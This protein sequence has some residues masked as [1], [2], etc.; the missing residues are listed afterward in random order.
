MKAVKNYAGLALM[1]AVGVAVIY[2]RWEFRI[3]PF[4]EFCESH[5]G[6]FIYWTETCGERK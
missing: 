4:A 5:G 2:I 1:F 3:K 6:H